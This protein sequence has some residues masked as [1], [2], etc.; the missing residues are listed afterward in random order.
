MRVIKS[1]K[2]MECTCV[3]CKSILEIEPQDVRYS[4][5]GHPAGEWFVCLVCGKI[6]SLD[7][8]LPKD[9]ISIIYREVSW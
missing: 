6:N 9:W 5:V 1:S 4:D 8:K 3:S 7:G 2:T